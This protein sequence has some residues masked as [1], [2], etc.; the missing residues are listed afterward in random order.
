[1]SPG[2]LASL[3]GAGVGISVEGLGGSLPALRKRGFSSLLQEKARDR[4]DGRS[5]LCTGHLVLR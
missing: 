2:G 3:I 1:M 5:H 4:E